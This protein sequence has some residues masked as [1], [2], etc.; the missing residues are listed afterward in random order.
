MTTEKNQNPEQ[1][2]R[3]KIDLML[4]E[5]GWV[6]QSKNEVDFVKQ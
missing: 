5:A 4:K 6:V 3:N 1:L 2:A